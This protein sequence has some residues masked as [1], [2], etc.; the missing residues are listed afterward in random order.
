[1]NTNKSSNVIQKNFRVSRFY[2]IFKC[3][4][5]VVLLILNF[6]FQVNGQVKVFSGGNTTVG[7][8]SQID[9]KFKLQVDGGNVSGYEPCGLYVK[10][11]GHQADYSYAQVNDVNRAN[12]KAF[13]VMLSGVSKYYIKGDG[14]TVYLS[15]SILKTDIQ[16]LGNSLTRVLSFNTY[17]YKFKDEL[18]TSDRT[19]IGFLAQ[20][21]ER[22]VP[23]IVSTDNQN[24]KGIDYVSIIPLLVKSIQELN[25]RIEV[26]EKQLQTCCPTNLKK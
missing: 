16:P 10:S 20:Q 15:D 24:L 13:E 17:T 18:A 22:V 3:Q 26:L 23:E 11:L 9:T 21:L 2:S 12:S 8:L 25:Q 7:T 4:T 19:R 14:S 1:M 5:A 6:V